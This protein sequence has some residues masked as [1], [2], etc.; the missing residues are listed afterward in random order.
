MEV[1][2]AGGLK[3]EQILISKYAVEFHYF[4]SIA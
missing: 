3:I 2:F 1:L 4:V